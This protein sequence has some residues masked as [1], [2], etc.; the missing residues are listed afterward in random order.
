MK[1]IIFCLSLLCSAS[2]YCQMSAPI[3]E[4]PSTLAGKV[5]NFGTF[6]GSLSYSIDD[7]DT[8]Y[9][10]CFRNYK[11]TTITELDHIRFGGEGGAVDSLFSLMRT[12]FADE[13]RKNK[14]YA[15]T[16]T[17]GKEPISISTYRSMGIPAVMILNREGYGL[18]TEKQ[19]AKLFG[20]N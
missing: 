18:F 6:V 7:K 3:K 20:K 13:N 1:L 9:D 16:V 5:N 14:D 4:A 8:V 12:V 15:V 19:L 17:L 2:A 11:Y 10:L